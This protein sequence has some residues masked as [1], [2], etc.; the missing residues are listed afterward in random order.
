MTGFERLQEQAKNQKNVHLKEVV[1]YLLAREDMEEKYLNEEKTLDGMCDFIKQKALKNAQDGWNFVSNEL[2]FSWAIMYFTF[3]NSFLK[4]ENK[5]SSTKKAKE[6]KENKTENKNN[7]VS[8]EDV[9]KKM[10]DKKEEVKQLSLFG[11]IA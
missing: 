10:E 11:G 9:K 6:V 3:P 7:I 5:S 2:V 4:I 1:N 8:L